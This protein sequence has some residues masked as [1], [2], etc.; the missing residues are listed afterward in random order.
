[1]KIT[2]IAVGKLSSMWKEAAKEY[3]KRIGRYCRV[4][5]IELQEEKADNQPGGST[6]TVLAKEAERI[7]RNIPAGSIACALDLGGESLSSESFANWLRTIWETSRDVCFIIGSHLGL[8]PEV[9]EKCQRKISFSAM[10]FP[11][12][13]ARIVLTEQ[14]Y[15]AFT[16]I[17][18]VPYHK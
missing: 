2:M 13:L 1:M 14:I 9:L 3:E 7:I 6:E 8:S 17:N 11:H 16:I 4:D 15:R 10:T 5:A 18:H 12:Q